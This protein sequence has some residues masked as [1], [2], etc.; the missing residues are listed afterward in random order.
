MFL[1]ILKAC[2]LFAAEFLK[3]SELGAEEGRAEQAELWEWVG[4]LADSTWE[5]GCVAASPPTPRRV[6]VGVLPRPSTLMPLCQ[7]GSKRMPCVSLCSIKQLDA[8]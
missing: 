3:G 7:L 1:L 6:C 2:F 5:P 8:S 4:N